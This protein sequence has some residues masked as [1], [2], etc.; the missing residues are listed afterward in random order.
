MSKQ[1]KTEDFI[2]AAREMHGNKYN[3]DYV[4]YQ[5]AIIKIDIFCNIH[6]IIFKQ[7]PNAHLNG[8]GCPQCGINKTTSGKLI[9]EEEYRE[10]LNK[11]NGDKY[12]YIFPKEFVRTSKIE[13]ICK[14]HQSYYAKLNKMLSGTQCKKCVSESYRLGKEKFL[15]R[16]MEI[17]NNNYTYDLT[18]YIDVQSIIDVICPLHGKFKTKAS[19]HMRGQGKCRQCLIDNAKIHSLSIT[20]D[21]N[22]W[23]KEAK[24]LHGNKYDYSKVIYINAH[25]KVEIICPKHG[26][27]WTIASLHRS[28]AHG[29]GCAKCTNKISKPE[30]E[31]L[32]LLEI[33][34]ENRNQRLKLTNKY[35]NV[36]AIDLENKIIYEFYGDFWHG[37][38]KIFDQNKTNPST[39]TTYGYLYQRTL[40]K[41]TDILAAGYKMCI[42]WEEDFY[43]L[44]LDGSI[45]K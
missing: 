4:N 43:K 30:T 44:G 26:S 41:E 33:P 17:H 25:S 19:I 27:F 11:L 29:Q 42:I 3:Y 16:I 34:K 7:T 35:Y 8:S 18:N 28:P 1:I 9:S 2:L 14:I 5:K 20:K 39:K 23:I 32:D 38:P 21:Q 31:W 45:W 36:D 6:K 24:D 13:V 12:S 10:R 15:N 22:A 37:N 40:S